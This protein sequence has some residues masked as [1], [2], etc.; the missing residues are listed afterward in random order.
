MIARTPDK[1]DWRGAPK[2]QLH[3]PQ[4]QPQLRRCPIKQNAFTDI[5][6]TFS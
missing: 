1:L 4:S 6:V 2:M 3:N 5:R